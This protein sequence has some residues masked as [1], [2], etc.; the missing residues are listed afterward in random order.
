MRFRPGARLDTGQIQDRRGVGGR[1]LALGGGAG[2]VLVVIVL[3]L[4][5]VDVNGGGADPYSLGTRS[6]ADRPTTQ[7]STTCRTGT[8]ANQ[9]DDCRIVAVVNSV[10]AYWSERGPRVPRGADAFLQ[11]AR[12]RPA[13]ERATSAVGPSTARPTARSTSTCASTT[14]CAQRFGAR[15]GPFAEAYVIAHEYGHHVQHL[16]GT[17]DRVGDDRQ[18]QS[19]GSVRL[20]LQADCYAGVW[21]ANAVETGFIEQLTE[22][23]IADGLDAAAAVGDDRIQEAP[24]GRV[25]PESWTHGSSAAAAALVRDAA[26]AAAIRA[27]ATRSR[28]AVC[29]PDLTHSRTTL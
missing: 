27:A 14:S 17:D 13:A 20:E 15:G 9:R 12:P 29:K 5:G 24:G 3:A 25:D 16:L 11:R 8:D 19:S 26:T 28:R 7:L 6:A 18:G 4:L 21:A 2:S 23:D 10:Q 22:A 1:G